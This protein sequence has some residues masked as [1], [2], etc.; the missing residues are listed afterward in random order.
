MVGLA[1][2]AFHSAITGH[3][4]TERAPWVQWLL[5]GVTV[6]VVAGSVGVWRRPK[7]A[8]WLFSAALAG[9]SVGTVPFALEHPARVLL[10]GLV[11]VT[12]IARLARG[13]I[14]LLRESL[15]DEARDSA[16]IAGAALLFAAPRAADDP[17]LTASVTS[18][19]AAALWTGVLFWRRLEMSGQKRRTLRIASAVGFTSVLAWPWSLAVAALV[20]LLALALSLWLTRQGDHEEGYVES[21][22][23]YPARFLVMTFATLGGLG[24]VLLTLPMASEGAPIGLLDA[25]F[26]AFSAVCVTGLIV[27]DTPTALSTFGEAIVLVLI[28]V[29]GLGIMGFSVA[30]FAVLHRRAS[31]RYEGAAAGVLGSERGPAL[32]R[33]VKRLFLM[34]GVIELATAAVLTVCFLVEGD[35]IAKAAWRGLFTAVSAFCNAGFSLQTDSLVPYQAN[36]V[37]LHTIGV[38]IIIGG[39]GPVVVTALPDFVRRRRT[40]AHVGIVL[41]TTAVLLFGGAF[42]FGA[43]EWRSSLAA[44]SPA[45]RIHNA[46]FQSITLRTAGFNSIDLSQLQDTSLI[47]MMALMMIG[48]SPG[49]TAGG[50][51]TTTIAILAL[52]VVASLRKQATATV[53]G[54][55]M[56]PNTMNKASAVLAVGLGALVTVLVVLLATQRIDARSLAF[57]TVSALGTV[58]LSVGAT[59]QLDAV[60]RIVVIVAMFLGRVGPLSLFLSLASRYTEAHWVLPEEDVPVG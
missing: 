57:E 14:P 41:V 24:A 35:G 1:V 3:P 59:S 27:L 11:G 9:F 50:V 45:D 28:Q 30:A 49:S 38:A 43:F 39:L 8:P 15:R 40:S 26:T 44:L 51:K 46:W 29:G 2:T 33:S 20:P 5:I 10:F 6:I 36:P 55:R 21:I 37:V 47:V 60:G 19:A 56:T 17:L 48:G 22:V 54:R 25:A 53:A 58:G 23:N 4:L 52:A 18:A 12:F 13:H 32:R 7:L 31:L 34:T 42:L 16:L